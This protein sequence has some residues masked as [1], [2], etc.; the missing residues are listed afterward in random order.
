M[1]LLAQQSKINPC[2]L[3]FFSEGYRGWFFKFD[4]TTKTKT[5]KIDQS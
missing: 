2:F 3:Q 1:S 5:E 4:L